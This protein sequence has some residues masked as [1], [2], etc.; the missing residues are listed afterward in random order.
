M[1]ESLRGDALRIK[2][3]T[4]QTQDAGSPLSQMGLGRSFSSLRL[5]RSPR[6][7]ASLAAPSAP[8]TPLVSYQRDITNKMPK[9]VE[10]YNSSFSRMMES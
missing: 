9:V 10:R 2:P 8:T 1:S 6:L 5:S 3:Y 7:S 4:P